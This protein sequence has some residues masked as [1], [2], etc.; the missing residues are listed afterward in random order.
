MDSFQGCYKDGTNGTRDCRYFAGLYLIVRI[1][2]YTGTI[3]KLLLPHSF[4][5]LEALLLVGFT[6]S[7][8]V[9]QPYKRSVHNT[10]D[11]I[12]LH[13]L[14]LIVFAY[15][16]VLIAGSASSQFIGISALVFE[17]S[18]LLP[19]LFVTG[20]AMYWIFTRRWLQRTIVRCTMRWCGR[21]VHTNSEESLPDRLV[22]A[23]EYAALLPEPVA[24]DNAESPQNSD[25][26]LPTY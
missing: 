11:S 3:I 5:P 2:L 26:E 7:V 4:S 19:L 12:I 21:I 24:D 1:L 14:I 9:I 18:F 20:Q 6:A 15:T 8:A 10:I 22:H 16:S 17:I 13:V 25:S 23:E